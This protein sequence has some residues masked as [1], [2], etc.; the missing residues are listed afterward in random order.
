MEFW[1]Q[2]HLLINNMYKQAFQ[3]TPSALLTKQVI[4]SAIRLNYNNNMHIKSSVG[5]FEMLL[6]DMHF[7]GQ[8][9]SDGS[10][11]LTSNDRGRFS[12]CLACCST[13]LNLLNS[14][15]SGA[16]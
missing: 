16:L 6:F 9:S 4:Q 12:G 11:H 14:T 1:I 8:L 15:H 3:P 7:P 5:H 13:P 10:W 2:T